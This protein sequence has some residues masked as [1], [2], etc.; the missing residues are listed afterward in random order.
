[1]S[2]GHLHKSNDLLEGGRKKTHVFC[3]TIV[4]TGWDNAFSNSWYCWNL[5]FSG[6]PLIIKYQ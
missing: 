4:L 3:S 5:A 6:L 2:Y 1:M